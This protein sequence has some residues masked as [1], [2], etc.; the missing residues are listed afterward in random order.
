MKTADIKIDN[1]PDVD[2]FYHHGI[3]GQKWGRQNG[4]PYPLDQSRKSYSEKKMAKMDKKWIRK[5]DKKIRKYADQ[6]A[7][8]ELREYEKELRTK[9]PK[10]NKN[11][12]INA[13]YATAYSKKMAEL[14]N[15]AIGDLAVGSG[16]GSG[17]VVK[18]VAA[19]GQLDVYT[20]LAD[21]GYNMANVKNGVY[22]SGRIG[23]K[24]E[25]VSVDYDDR[26]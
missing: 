2:E 7:K 14:Y 24:K 15:E 19:R 12:K 23:Y 5:N 13:N 10:Y 9:I 6:S 16:S 8:E 21:Y 11:G 26:K 20:A 1:L 25:S 17:K 18:F 22:G 4:P 3:L